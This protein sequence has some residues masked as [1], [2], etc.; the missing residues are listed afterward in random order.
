MTASIDRV[1]VLWGG[2]VLAWGIA[3]LYFWPRGR[4]GRG[5]APWKRRGRRHRRAHWWHWRWPWSAIISAR[6][7]ARAATMDLA[8]LRAAYNVYREETLRFWALVE[9]IL[10]ENQFRALISQYKRELD[11]RAAGK[12]SGRAGQQQ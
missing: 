11:E 3:I 12:D 6:M 9:R 10:P 2:I 8:D 7:E 5:D 1:S 4:T